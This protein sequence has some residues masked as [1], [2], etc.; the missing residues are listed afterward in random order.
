MENINTVTNDYVTASSCMPGIAEIYKDGTIKFIS[1][2]FFELFGLSP[3]QQRPTSLYQH[4]RPYLD[5]FSSLVDEL[6]AITSGVSFRMELPIELH[7][8]HHEVRTVLY[9]LTRTDSETI[10]VSIFDCTELDTL[11]MQINDAT[12]QQEFQQARLDVTSGVLHDI[13]NAISGISLRISQ[14]NGEGEWRELTSLSQ[15]QSFLA[16]HKETLDEVLGPSKSKALE[17][18]ATSLQV[19]LASRSRDWNANVQFLSRGIRHIEELISMHQHHSTG[20]SEFEKTPVQIVRA[21]NDS[22]AMLNSQIVKRGIKVTLQQVPGILLVLGDRN[23]LVSVFLNVIKNAYE[24]LDM[25]NEDSGDKSIDLLCSFPQA[26]VI[27]IVVSDNGVGFEPDKAE[28]FFHGETSTKQRSSGLG[29]QRC[30]H[31]IDN[32][33]GKIWMTSDG[34]GLGAKVVIELPAVNAQSG[35]AFDV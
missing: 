16:S 6:S 26:D 13:A 25:R 33:R 34:V 35:T 7:D 2:S 22:L 24:S 17:G 20:S 5:N 14:I 19:T 8:N 11:R 3:Q 4:F 23:R 30:R 1:D 12:R 15:L 9:S 28:Q 21:L 32:H 27:Q 31:I 18:F 29:L 10:I